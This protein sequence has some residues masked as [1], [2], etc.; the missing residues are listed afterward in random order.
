M[1]PNSP[2]LEGVLTY[3]GIHGHPTEEEFGQGLEVKSAYAKQFQDNPAEDGSGAARTLGI[4][5]L[6]DDERLKLAA[7]AF[8]RFGVAKPTSLQWRAAHDQ[9]FAPVLSPTENCH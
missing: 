1:T 2:F 4:Y 6:F 5:R 8:M 7:I 3:R 9:H